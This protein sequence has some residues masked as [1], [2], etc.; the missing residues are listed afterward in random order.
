MI[1]GGIGYFAIVF[2]VAFGFGT[3]RTLWLAPA[4]GATGAVLVELP[5]ILIVSFVAA[6]LVVARVRP[7]PSGTAIGIG[8][9]GFTLLMAAE[10]GLGVFAFGMSLSA[11]LASLVRVPGV[12]G[13]AGQLAFAAMP[14]IVSA[15]QS[16]PP[17]AQ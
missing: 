14:L 17:R 5:L 9:I 8:A 7:A 10:A 1:S 16:S 11:W 3:V 2:I 13:L 15:R 6:R 4:I 12:F